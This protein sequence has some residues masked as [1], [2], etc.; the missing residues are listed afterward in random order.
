MCILKNTTIYSGKQKCLILKIL[1]K[2]GY[3]TNNLVL[4]DNIHTWASSNG[5]VAILRDVNRLGGIF[6]Y[7][8][9]LTKTDRDMVET[10]LFVFTNV[11]PP[12]QIQQTLKNTVFGREPLGNYLKSKNQFIEHR[13][14]HEVA[15]A[16]KGWDES[17]EQRCD[18]WALQ[19]MGISNSLNPSSL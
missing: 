18:E 5:V 16:L 6:D 19:E 3:D 9:T 4:T 15:H 1:R 17:D 13:V 2:Y 7:A 14:L 8:L 10:R 12:S 11:I